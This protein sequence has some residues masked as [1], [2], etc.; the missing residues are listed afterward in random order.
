MCVATAARRLSFPMQTPFGA[1]TA[2]LN[3]RIRAQRTEF[4]L[5]PQAQFDRKRL[6]NGI[7]SQSK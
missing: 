1:L 2:V 3:S 7:Q 6:P 5:S 4:N